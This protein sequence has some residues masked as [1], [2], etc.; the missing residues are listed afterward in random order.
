MLAK[1]SIE[2]KA[3][4]EAKD[5]GYGV[6]WVRHAAGYI[7]NLMA[8]SGITTRLFSLPGTEYQMLAHPHI[9]THPDEGRNQHRKQRGPRTST[10]GNVLTQAARAP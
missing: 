7:Q 6:T 10:S 8:H 3:Q 4:C 5:N 9:R 1:R 2:S